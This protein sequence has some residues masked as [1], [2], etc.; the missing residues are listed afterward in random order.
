MEIEREG[1][2]VHWYEEKG[3]EHQRNKQYNIPC[4]FQHQKTEEEQ[5]FDTIQ[6]YTHTDT[7][8]VLVLQEVNEAKV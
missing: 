3:S 5:F 1:E 8:V 6:C 4:S 7:T 2:K